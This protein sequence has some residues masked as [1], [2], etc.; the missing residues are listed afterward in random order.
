MI[1]VLGFEYEGRAKQYYIQDGERYD[2]IYFAVL[3]K[4]VLTLKKKN[5]NILY[6]TEEL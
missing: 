5:G 1:G 3:Q 6:K 2:A 4:L